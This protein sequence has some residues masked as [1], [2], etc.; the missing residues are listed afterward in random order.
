MFPWN[1]FWE[2]LLY[3]TVFRF[4]KKLQ[5]TLKSV[6]KG[7]KWGKLCF[8]DLLALPNFLKSTAAAIKPV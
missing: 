6:F 4:A 2:F 8:M 5:F 3:I 1:M 7:L